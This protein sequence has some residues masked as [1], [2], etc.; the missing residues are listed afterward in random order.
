MNAAAV[1]TLIDTRPGAAERPAVEPR[2]RGRPPLDPSQRSNSPDADRARRRRE[3]LKR[4]GKPADNR[5]RFSPS[6]IAPPT[7]AAPPPPPRPE[8]SPEM[9]SRAKRFVAKLASGLS[10]A[11]AK[12]WHDD[13]LKITTVEADD[14]GESILDGWPELALLDEDGAKWMAALVV[15]SIIADRYGKHTTKPQNGQRPPG[16]PV[17]VVDAPRAG[18]MGSLEPVK[19]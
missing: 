17:A 12:I 2:G 7:P 9:T 18:S 3:E 15:G 1:A 13:G 16:E 11:C 6:A 10:V 14:V 19:M 5:P 4:A 8:V